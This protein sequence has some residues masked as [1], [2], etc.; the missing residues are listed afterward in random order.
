[1]IIRCMSIFLVLCVTSSWGPASWADDVQDKQQGTRPV[2]SVIIAFDLKDRDTIL[3]FINNFADEFAF[4][5]RIAPTSPN[6]RSF[7]ID[8]W[9]RDVRIV[10]V[11]PLDTTELHIYFYLNSDKSISIIEFNIKRMVDF[12]RKGI[13]LEVI[14]I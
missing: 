14:P 4:A 3:E 12:F 8:M 6:W 5:I 10:G 7:G 13:K 1:M 9:R 2:R 11:N